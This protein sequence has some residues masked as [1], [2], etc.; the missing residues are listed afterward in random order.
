MAKQN[1]TNEDLLKSIKLGCMVPV[2]Q[3]AL[4]DEDILFLASE[5]LELDVVS[6]VLKAREEYYV[7]VKQYTK[8]NTGRYE[9]PSRATASRLRS[10]FLKDNNNNLYK[11]SEISVDEVPLVQNYYYNQGFWDPMFYIQNDEV[12]FL[13]NT[14]QSLNAQ[15]VEMHYYLEPNTLVLPERCLKITS[16]DTNSGVI[17]VEERQVP[18][19]IAADSQIDFIQYKPSNKIKSMDISVVS[20]SS[21]SPVS[22]QKYI[23]VDPSDIPD[24]LEVG[25]WIASAGETPVPQLVANLRPLLAQATI[26]RILESQGDNNNIAIAM[27]KLEKMVKGMKTLVQDRTE[28]NP[29][30]V[31]NRTGV[32]KVSLIGWNG[33]RRKGS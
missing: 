33:S 22:S 9:I 11:C 21:N 30:K 3:I 12:V 18:S 15:Y 26:C 32:M 29:K 14:A 5:E 13:N 1:Y 28:G 4:S 23:T 20:V 19:N 6:S 7:Y 27:K 10:V 24:D 16:I 17:E 8:N 31:V 2:D 25:D